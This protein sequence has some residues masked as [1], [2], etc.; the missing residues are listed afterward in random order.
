MCAFRVQLCAGALLISEIINF[1]GNSSNDGRV[2]AVN[3]S[4]P[5]TDSF[6]SVA[7]SFARHSYL[8][9]FYFEALKQISINGFKREISDLSA[10]LQF[11]LNRYLRSE[12]K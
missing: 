5:I 2:D 1:L 3:Y 4:A 7:S 10:E 8:Q 6:Q 11:Y 12:N 9:A